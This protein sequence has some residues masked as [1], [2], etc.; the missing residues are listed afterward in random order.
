MLWH[1]GVN[2]SHRLLARKS[3]WN[4]SRGPFEWYVPSC[5]TYDMKYLALTYVCVSQW[6]ICILMKVSVYAF[7]SECIKTFMICMILQIKGVVRELTPKPTF[8]LFTATFY[9]AIVCKPRFLI[10]PTVYLYLLSF[11]FVYCYYCYYYDYDYGYMIMIVMIMIMMI[12]HNHL[13]WLLLWYSN[14]TDSN[15]RRLSISQYQLILRSSSV[16][17][18]PSGTNSECYRMYVCIC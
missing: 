12:N 16:V 9:D 7:P 6:C 4:E 5:T 11:F 14:D 10:R 1:R 15:Q 13:H 2:V 17:L 18:S 8:L 3:L